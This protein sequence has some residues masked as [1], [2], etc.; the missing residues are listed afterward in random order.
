MHDKSLLYCIDAIFVSSSLFLRSIS[1]QRCS[2][3]IS[4]T[5]L[6]VSGMLALTSG[7]IQEITL[8]YP[9]QVLTLEGCDIHTGEEGDCLNFGIP[10]VIMRPAV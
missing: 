1:V 5:L 3:P 9:S 7:R 8:V 2:W 4:H 10:E 6:L